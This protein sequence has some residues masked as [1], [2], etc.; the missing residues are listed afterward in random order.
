MRKILIITLILIAVPIYTYNVY[1]LLSGAVRGN[2]ENSVDDLSIHNNLSI[3]AILCAM[4]SVKFVLQG[5]SPFIAYPVSEKPAVEKKDTDAKKQKV[6]KAPQEMPKITISGIMWNDRNPLAMIGLADGSSTV[7][8]A[9]Q[10][11]GDI[12]IKK[13]EKTSVVIVVDKSEFRIMR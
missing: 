7:A 5:R 1:I 3:D 10:T 9:G 2:S 13:I 12:F 8:K 11:I 4:D 6:T